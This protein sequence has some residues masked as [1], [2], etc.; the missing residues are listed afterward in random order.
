MTR[1]DHAMTN[2][3]LYRIAPP[4]HASTDALR[5]LVLILAT[6][7]I[8]VAVTASVP[9]QVWTELSPQADTTPDWHGNV[10]SH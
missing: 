8:G 4:R 7:L 3:E 10:A 6:V 5:T 9:D 1:Q 2:H